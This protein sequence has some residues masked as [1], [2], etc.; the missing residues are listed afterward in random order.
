MRGKRRRRGREVRA[1]RGTE[2]AGGVGR[3]GA[4][5]VEYRHV[6]GD[7]GGRGP[8][9]GAGAEVEEGRRRRGLDVVGGGGDLKSCQPVCRAKPSMPGHT[10]SLLGSLSGAIAGAPSPLLVGSLQR[11]GAKN[12][13]RTPVKMGLVLVAAEEASNPAASGGRA[14]QLSSP[15]SHADVAGRLPLAGSPRPYL[16]PTDG[17]LGEKS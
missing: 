16:P 5:G 11:G 14:Q 2:K 6:E 9:R 4:G 15:P 17:L 1:R 3:W 8:C 7:C 13:R 10:Y 12:G